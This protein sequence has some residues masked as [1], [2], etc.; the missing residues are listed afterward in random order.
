[1]FEEVRTLAGQGFGFAAL[2]LCMLAFASKRDERLMLWLISANVAFALQFFSLGSWTAGAL[3]LL[4]ILRIVL[5]RRFPGS[6]PVMITVL[7]ISGAAAVVTWRGWEDLASVV[8]MLLGTVGMFL[9][10]GIA[11][12]VLL[13]LA[14]CAWLTSHALVGSVGG[15]L[16][17]T[18][19]LAT[20]AVTIY[21]LLVARRR[22]ARAE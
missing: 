22:L 20:N 3:T 19:V 14:A 4:V 8:A 21:R 6:V 5:A 10:R 1:M 18:L 2:L 17:E 7:A 12:R 13:G 15:V 9:F 11:M 16:A